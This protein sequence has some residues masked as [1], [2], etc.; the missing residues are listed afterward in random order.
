ML[1]LMLRILSGALRDCGR[2]ADVPTAYRQVLELMSTHDRA[3][4]RL[5]PRRAS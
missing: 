5:T 4:A 2:E 3:P 1:M